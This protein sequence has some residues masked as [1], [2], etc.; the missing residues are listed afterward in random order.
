MSHYDIIIIGTGAG[1]GTLAHKLASS[2]KKM[3]ILERG[4]FI[5]REKEN[6]ETKAVFNQGR[7]KAKE[8]WYDKNAKTFHPGIHYCVGGN[9]KV[10][11]SALLRL[12]EKDF[13][14]LTHKDG[15][16]P[17]WPI[18]YAD[19]AKYYTEAE[20]MY[21]VHGERGSDPTDPPEDTPYRHAPLAHEP[22]VQKLFDDLKKCGHHPFPQ[23]EGEK[24]G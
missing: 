20:H 24:G 10:Y 1:G 16:S 17:E 2:G 7:Y 9:T 22:R 4:N 11:G 6:W 15:V 14:E 23:W 12:R 13:E 5:P 3:L 19:L 21:H 8:T 18:K